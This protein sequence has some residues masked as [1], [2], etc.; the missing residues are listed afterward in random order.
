M[1]LVEKAKNIL[2][3]PKQ[4]WEVSKEEKTTFSSLLVGYVVPLSLIGAVAHFIGYGLIGLDFG[5][6]KIKGIDFGIKMAISYI[7][8]AIIGYVGTTYVVDLLAPSFESEKNLDKSARLVAYSQT[9]SLI[10]A[11]FHIIPSLSVLGI[12]GLYGAYVAWLGISPMKN[13]PEAK[14]VGYVVAIILTS[15]VIG[16]VIGFIAE[17]IFSTS[18]SIPSY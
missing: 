1:N 2:L 9:A 14:K 5:M 4:E 10:A 17:K 3:N 12:V 6:V 11:V 13:T 7:I 8:G 16:L 18:P 15:I